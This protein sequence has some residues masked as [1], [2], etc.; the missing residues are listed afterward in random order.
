MAGCDMGDVFQNSMISEEIRHRLDALKILSGI[1]ICYNCKTKLD[2]RDTDDWHGKQQ[3]KVIRTTIRIR[4]DL[5][6]M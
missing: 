1:A 6:S 4:K 2:Q 3:Q 5:G